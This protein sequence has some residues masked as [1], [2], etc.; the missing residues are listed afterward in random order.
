LRQGLLIEDPKAVISQGQ[1]G[2]VK[3][4]H[5]RLIPCCVVI[6][7]ETLFCQHDFQMYRRPNAFTSK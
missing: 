2:G 5:R 1:T 4:L 3:R 6:A 7:S